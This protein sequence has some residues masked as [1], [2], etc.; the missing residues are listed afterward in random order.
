MHFDLLQALLIVMIPPHY[1]KQ[2]HSLFLK[3]IWAHKQSCLP[4][5]QLSLHKQYGG[6]AIPDGLKYN[7]AT[8]LS[9]FLDWRHHAEVKLWAQIE[10]AQ[11]DIPL[12]GTPWCY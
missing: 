8:Y 11:T 1:F 12:N 4:H 2:V 7:Q 10:Q 5:S 3:F 9:R 6:L